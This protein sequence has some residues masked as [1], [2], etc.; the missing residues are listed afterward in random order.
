MNV[1]ASRRALGRLAGW[2]LLIPGVLLCAPAGVR[3]DC[4]DY[5]T[6]RSAHSGA[7]ST[8]AP[9][10]APQPGKPCSGP[11]CSQ[12]PAAPLAPAPTPPPTS[13]EWGALLD[14]LVLAAPRPAALFAEQPARRPVRRPA[15]VFH[16]PRRAS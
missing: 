2:A 15:D 6:T 4:G 3:A 1:A 14:A 9:P 13:S 16:P 10:A 11:H 7:P 8:A 5:V 12:T